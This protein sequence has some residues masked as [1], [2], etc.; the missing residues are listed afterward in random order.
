MKKLEKFEYQS[1]LMYD[2]C[3]DE[4]VNAGSYQ[5]GYYIHT[6]ENFEPKNFYDLYDLMSEANKIRKALEVL[7]KDEFYDDENISIELHFCS[8]VKANRLIRVLDDTI[9]EILGRYYKE[10]TMNK[11]FIEKWF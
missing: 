2:N 6:L 8:V 1:T 7:R 4:F 10:V 11:T 3:A 5:L 9:L